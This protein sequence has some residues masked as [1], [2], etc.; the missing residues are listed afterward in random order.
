MI[1]KGMIAAAFLACPALVHGNHLQHQ[2]ESNK[3]QLVQVKETVEDLDSI[4]D[5]LEDEEPLPFIPSEPSLITEYVNRYGIRLWFML[6]WSWDK[7][8]AFYAL[9]PAWSYREK[10]EL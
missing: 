6:E 9:L 7:I 3:I 5:S 4:L 10:D 1:Y 8:V 2:I